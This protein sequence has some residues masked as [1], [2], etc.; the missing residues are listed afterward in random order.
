M[1]KINV[2]IEIE[3]NSN[4]K[5]EYDKNEKKL[6]I[7][8]ILNEPFIYP[9]AYGFIPNTLA[10]DNDELDVLIITDKK[11]NNDF[12]Y[13]VHIIGALAME[14][15]KGMDEKILCVLNEDYE[16]IKDI[17]DLSDKIKEKIFYFFSNYKNNISGKWSKVN[18]FINKK[19]AIQLYEKSIIK[20]K[21]NY[22]ESN[23]IESNYQ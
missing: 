14:D 2:Y 9:Y 8:R 12:F 22:I 5:Y 7:D 16:N 18:D 10:N 11:L 6:I 15:E 17:Y 4:I 3:K 13:D 1:N 20:N 19:L 21:N 23:Y